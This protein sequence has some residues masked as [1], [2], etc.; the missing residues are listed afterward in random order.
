MITIKAD[1]YFGPQEVCSIKF[2]APSLADIKD[3]DIPEP[4]TK[5]EWQE[6]LVNAEVHERI[7]DENYDC[8]MIDSDEYWKEQ[9]SPLC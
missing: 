2:D 8:A 5:V 9:A 3:E 6:A 4:Y 1:I 7:G